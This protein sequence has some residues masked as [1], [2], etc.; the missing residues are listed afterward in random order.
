FDGESTGGSPKS[1]VIQASNGKLYGTTSYSGLYNYGTLFEFD[2]QTGNLTKKADFDREN[3]GRQIFSN[4]MQASNGNLYGVTNR[5][6]LFDAGT[7][8][9]YDYTTEV[10]SKL[11]DFSSDTFGFGPTVLVELNNGVLYGTC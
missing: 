10:F 11:V 1:Q 5:G 8:Y 7:L 9:E 4:V 6:G 2:I 3:T